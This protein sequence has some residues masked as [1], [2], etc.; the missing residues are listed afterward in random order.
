MPWDDNGF[1]LDST[2]IKEPP[3]EGYEPGD[4]IDSTGQYDPWGFDFNG[5]HK[6][7]GT[8]FNP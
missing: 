1:G 3:Y 7:T 6:D 5:I 2:Y 8:G 4:P